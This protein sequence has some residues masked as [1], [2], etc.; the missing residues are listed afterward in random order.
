LHHLPDIHAC[1]T[2]A[3]TCSFS[4]ESSRGRQP[5]PC[6]PSEGSEFRRQVFLVRRGLSA[7][8]ACIRTRGDVIGSLIVISKA[9]CSPAMGRCLLVGLW[10]TLSTLI[11]CAPLFAAH[12]HP[13][14]AGAI[15]LIFSTV[16]HQNPTRSFM[17]GSYPLAV[18]QRCSGIYAALFLCSLIPFAKDFSRSS[19]S[20]RRIFVLCCSFPMVL[21]AV[22]SLA[23]IWPSAPLI[24][25]I[26]G[27]IFGSMISFLLIPGVNDLLR[28]V[29]CRRLFA[30]TPVKGE[31]S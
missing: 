5:S 4:P 28:L 29:S 24:R 3:K 18:C 14:A 13:T 1:N 17:L 25:C 15:Y 22:F 31:F 23:G 20:Q 11:V 7:I 12:A 30:A 27:F 16:C 26:T 8:M 6:G 19:L 10:G 21:D 2:R 9:R